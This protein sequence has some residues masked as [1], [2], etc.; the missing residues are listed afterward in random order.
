M[1]RTLIRIRKI[2]K[3]KAEILDGQHRHAR[4]SDKR[5]ELELL[6]AKQLRAEDRPV[7]VSIPKSVPF[8]TRLASAFTHVFA[9]AA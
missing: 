5:R 2:E 9:R 8:L 7:R 4:I 3:L 1:W 6:V